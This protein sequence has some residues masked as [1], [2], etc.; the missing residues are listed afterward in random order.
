MNSSFLAALHYLR[1]TNIVGGDEDDFRVPG[2]VD[3]LEDL[4]GIRATTPHL[5]V[6][7]EITLWTKVP[8]NQTANC[9]AKRLFLVRAN[10]DQV[11]VRRLDA[12]GEGRTDTGT[13]A[14][15]NAAL[16]ERR[17]VGNASKL[18]LARP[19]LPG[20]IID[21]TLSEVTLDTTYEVM[22]FRVRALRDDTEGVVL[23]HGAP[24]DA[25]K[26]SL[27]HAALEAQ[28]RYLWRGE[29]DIDFHISRADPWKDD[30]GRHADHVPE[31]L[32]VDNVHAADVPR[33]RRCV[34][35][36]SHK[37][38]DPRE[39]ERRPAEEPVVSLEDI[40]VRVTDPRE[41]GNGG[42]AHGSQS[43][44]SEDQNDF[45]LACMLA[46]DVAD[47]E[48][49]PDNSRNSATGVNTTKMLEDGC[50]AESP[51]QRCPL[52]EAEVH[53][54]VQAASENLVAHKDRDVEVRDSHRTAILDRIRPMTGGR[55]PKADDVDD[56]GDGEQ[57]TV[58]VVPQRPED[59]FGHFLLLGLARRRLGRRICF[60]VSDGEDVGD[61]EV[62]LLVL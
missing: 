10:P 39:E 2:F 53:K 41:P 36:V 11:P 47:P 54:A 56:K 25:G 19:N 48:T 24:A 40:V 61:N 42:D 1:I 35:K 32:L 59:P 20:R 62:L 31:V 46:E 43:Q 58:H 37:D 18:Q 23:L 16:V 8:V 6:P 12:S 28:D 50:A 38:E 21:K 7:Q 49:K 52:G 30:P 60:L 17:G 14:D 4:H 5:T 27:L 57:F 3:L 33:L 15:T 34:P 9:R 55:E 29:L 45:A 26:Q 22:V 13:S 44:D 51:P